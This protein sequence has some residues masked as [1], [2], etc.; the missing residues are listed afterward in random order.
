M[1]Q[2]VRIR[3]YNEIVGKR[4]FGGSRLVAAQRNGLTRMADKAR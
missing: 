3:L 1:R 4:A 2:I